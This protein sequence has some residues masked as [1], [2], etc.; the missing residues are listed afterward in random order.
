MTTTIRSILINTCMANV[1][2][3]ISHLEHW[4]HHLPADPSTA[5][6]PTTAS[7]SAPTNIDIASLTSVVNRLSEQVAL[8]QHTLHNILDRLTILENLRQ[9]HIDDVSQASNDPW[10]DNHCIPLTNEVI[11]EDCLSEEPLYTFHKDVS[12][13]STP[14]EEIVPAPVVSSLPSPLAPIAPPTTPALASPSSVPAPLTSTHEPPGQ[15]EPIVEK[16]EE[17]KEPAEVEEE[18][19]EEEVEEEVIEEEVAEEVVVEEEVIEEEV[20]EEEGEE[21]EE[22][23][24]KDVTYAKDGEG[25]IYAIDE[26]GAPSDNPIGYWKEKTQSIAFYKTK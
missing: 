22:I 5:T 26:D 20:E 13:A 18:V 11:G 10:M 16:K 15:M 23:T 25:F 4:L 3:E 7:V 19:V 9:V 12:P 8:Q 1:Q 24:Y 14:K 17:A 6:A 21:L 2:K